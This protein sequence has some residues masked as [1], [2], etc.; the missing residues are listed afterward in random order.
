[1][2]DSVPWK[3]L[4]SFRSGA[5]VIDVDV[6]VPLRGVVGFIPEDMNWTERPRIPVMM[7]TGEYRNATHPCH[8]HLD[9]TTPLGLMHYALWCAEQ[10][11]GTVPEMRKAR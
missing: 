10:P 11:D 3:T 6:D 1:M 5:P 9:L 8:Y 4:G 7:E 2:P